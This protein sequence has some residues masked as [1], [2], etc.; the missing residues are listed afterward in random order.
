MYYLLI[1]VYCFCVCSSLQRAWSACAEE[2]V[3]SLLREGEVSTFAARP[4]LRQGLSSHS[5]LLHFVHYR[6]AAGHCSATTSRRH[7]NSHPRGW[8]Y[9]GA[10]HRSDVVGPRR[11]PSRLFLGLSRLGHG[12]GIARKRSPFQHGCCP[13]GIIPPAR[14]QSTYCTQGPTLPN[15]RV[16]S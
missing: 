3:H 13:S 9:G 15:A 16:F 10:G 5:P 12:S 1:Q 4:L 11:L 8:G 2:D 6:D 14:T 7:S